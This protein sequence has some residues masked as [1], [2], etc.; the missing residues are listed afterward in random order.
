MELEVEHMHYQTVLLNGDWEMSYSQ[1]VYTGKACPWKTGEMVK[2]AVPGYWEEMTDMFAETQ[3][4]TDLKINPEYG[5]QRYPMRQSVP[6]M[7]LPNITG[8]F[9]YRRSFH[10]KT[11]AGAQT[12]HFGGVQNAA[13]VWINGTYLGRHEGYSTPFELQ[14]PAGLLRNG[15]NEAGLCITNIDLTGFNQEPVSGLTNRAACQ[16]TGGIAGDIE[17]RL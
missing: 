17:L 2:N 13:S 12:I 5:I 16:Y 15:E 8:N 14:I 10:L 6:D 1:S 11:E 4:Y 3:F 7:A 9:F